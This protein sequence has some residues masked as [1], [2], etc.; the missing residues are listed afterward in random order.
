MPPK[1]LASA[2]QAAVDWAQK[3]KQ[4][5][6][7]AAELRATR[8]FAAEQTQLQNPSDELDDEDEPAED[9]PP[10]WWEQPRP[11]SEERNSPP[12]VR[13]HARSPP[14]RKNVVSHNSLF[15]QARYSDDEEVE[16]QIFQETEDETY[17]DYRVDERH[18]D[19]EQKPNWNSDFADDNPF[20]NGFG[21][22]PPKKLAPG[23]TA[24]RQAQK[25]S[26][27]K[28]QSLQQQQPQQ[29]LQQKRQPVGAVPSKSNI[30]KAAAPPV[31]KW[32]WG[33]DDVPIGQRH[34]PPIVNDSP[35]KGE[36]L[37]VSEAGVVATDFSRMPKWLQN[38]LQERENE[39]LSDAH[40]RPVKN[41]RAS[42]AG[43]ESPHV[44]N[45]QA[46]LA[47]AKVDWQQ[48]EEADQQPQPA[49]SSRQKADPKPPASSRQS[50]GG[51]SAT[52][53]IFIPKACKF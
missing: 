46:G 12:D 40:E 36:L 11:V 23:T 35:S 26:S 32:D 22:P 20:R 25:P 43:P 44:K 5:L 31:K 24:A 50:I 2:A 47:A 27:S 15:R 45:S 33:N 19:I 13:F 38:K 7:K 48:W 49:A 14:M 3:R 28:M 17:G 37:W 52:F 21:M 30:K 53:V 16:E 10:A 9:V 18:N 39:R 1:R 42:S 29:S 4:A 41:R 51:E 34:S 6:E 8:K